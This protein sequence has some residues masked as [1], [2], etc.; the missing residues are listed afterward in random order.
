M[1]NYRFEG[2]DYSFP[3]DVS[4][5]EVLDFLSKQPPK[6]NQA[7]AMEQP[8]P[9]APVQQPGLDASVTTAPVI[10]K[11]SELYKDPY[12]VAA[13]KYIRDKELLLDKEVERL[14][15]Q[16][17]DPMSSPLE[18]DVA[19][20]ALKLKKSRDLFKGTDEEYAEWGMNRIGWFL[21]N[22]PTMMVDAAE[23]SYSTD[24]SEKEAFL[25]LME[26]YERTDPS[27]AGLGRWAK[28][29]SLDPTTW[30]G[31]GS[32]GAGLLARAGGQQLTKE[33][34]K[35]LLKEGVRVGT[36]AAIDTATVAAA[37]DNMKQ[38]IEVSAGVKQG[39]DWAQ[40]GKAALIG[41][42]FGFALGGALGAGAG[43]LGQ[44]AAR[45]K[46]AA[47]VADDAADIVDGVS[48]RQPDTPDTLSLKADADEIMREAAPAASPEAP[49]GGLDASITSAPVISD[50]LPKDLAGA[51]PRYNY[52][53]K[54]F[55]LEFESDVERALFIT[56]RRT[57]PSVTLTIGL[58]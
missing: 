2:Q 51:K 4:G 33:G 30:T 40:T 50:T 13:A 12:F 17:D 56:S 26:A 38:S 43:A 49:S 23:I 11:Q 25:Y 44:R 34:F 53:R 5:E 14:Q 54:G 20:K 22:L 39:T 24:Q 41:G 21:Y 16:I 7:P 10:K 45:N 36:I 29:A 18:R 27:L 3:D 1:A 9:E 58:G 6:G 57:L 48:T 46:A 31:I 42:A 28:G 52:G 32:L 37:Q 55:G 15:M 19:E 35:A 47:G 8:A